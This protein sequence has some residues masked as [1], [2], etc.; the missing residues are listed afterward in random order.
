MMNISRRALRPRDPRPNLPMSWSMNQWMARTGRTPNSNMNSAI[1][2]YWARAVSDEAAVWGK[3]KNRELYE[4]IGRTRS[5]EF[6]DPTL[7]EIVDCATGE[8]WSDL[9]VMHALEAPNVY[10]FVRDRSLREAFDRFVLYGPLERPAYLHALKAAGASSFGRV[11]A[12]R[13]IFEDTPTLS[14]ANVSFLARNCALHLTKKCREIVGNDVSLGIYP[15]MLGRNARALVDHLRD[16]RIRSDGFWRNDTSTRRQIDPECW[17][18]SDFQIDLVNGD[19]INMGTGV[20]EYG[21]I[22]LLAPTIGVAEAVECGAPPVDAKSKPTDDEA[23]AV[24]RAE[25]ERNDGFVAQKIGAA[26]V[27]AVYPQF[28]ET[29][30]RALVKELTGNAKRGPQGSRKN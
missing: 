20:I 14:L 7:S 21:S 12:G 18:R 5:I 13:L 17:R 9:R 27:R 1:R 23:R 15:E 11:V 3:A 10:E 22:M 2:S 28:N 16:G 4:P 19:L 8:S 6:S 26:A 30:A 29:R 25:M 24:I